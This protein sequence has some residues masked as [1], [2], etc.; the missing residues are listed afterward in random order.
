MSRMI[1]PFDIFNVKWRYHTGL[2]RKIY[3][4][5]KHDKTKN[6]DVFALF[7]FAYN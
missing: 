3:T 7:R 4:H 1:P 2:F 5:A 6:L